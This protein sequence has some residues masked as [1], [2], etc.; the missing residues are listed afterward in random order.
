MQNKHLN[1]SKYF[2]DVKKKN[3]KRCSINDFFWFCKR[4][5]GERSIVNGEYELGLTNLLF[6]CPEHEKCLVGQVKP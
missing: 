5:P 4:G 3:F 6:G 2:H 1:Q